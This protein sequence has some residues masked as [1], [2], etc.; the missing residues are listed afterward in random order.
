MYRHDRALI[1]SGGG[2][3]GAYEIGVWKYLCEVKWQPDLICGTSVGAIN[4]AGITAGLS[5][6]D[7]IGLDHVEFAMGCTGA[8]GD[9]GA[10]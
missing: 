1:L 8:G 3:R 7:L 2:T 5:L 6:D 9:G 4:G 10:V